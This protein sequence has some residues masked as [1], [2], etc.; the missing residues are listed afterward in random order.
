MRAA[1]RATT[2][3]LTPQIECVRRRDLIEHRVSRRIAMQRSREG[4]AC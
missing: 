1:I 4:R 3:R 2:R